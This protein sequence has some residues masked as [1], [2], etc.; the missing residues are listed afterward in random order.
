MLNFPLD[1]LTIPYFPIVN[2]NLK[3][4]KSSSVLNFKSSFPTGLYI[5]KIR[6]LE[7]SGGFW[8]ITSISPRGASNWAINKTLSSS[9]S[10]C[11]W[12]ATKTKGSFCASTPC[13]CECTA[14]L[15]Q[16]V[17]FNWRTSKEEQEL[18]VSLHFWWSGVNLLVHVCTDAK[19]QTLA[20]YI[21]VCVCTADLWDVLF[22]PETV[23][24]LSRQFTKD[25]LR[26]L[27]IVT[28]S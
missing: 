22:G 4:P 28:Q 7:S 21:K 23:S 24:T 19:T 13:F 11:R 18:C 17:Q 27:E 5:S 15:T 6:H 12:P 9:E 8:M 14:P 16:A 3:P 26:L 25:L 1:V 2:V 10:G 20:K